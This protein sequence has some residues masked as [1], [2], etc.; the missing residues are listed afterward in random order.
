MILNE[1][2][3]SVCVYFWDLPCKP[4]FEAVKVCKVWFIHYLRLWDQPVVCDS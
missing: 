1:A 3:A 4:Q 2:V